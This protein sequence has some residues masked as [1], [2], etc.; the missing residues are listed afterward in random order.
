MVHTQCAWAQ[1]SRDQQHIIT[2]P[3]PLTGLPGQKGEHSCRTTAWKAEK[4]LFSPFPHGEA[5]HLCLYR[6]QPLPKGTS[7]AMG[8]SHA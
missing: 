3:V 6:K 8:K 4:G 7:H 5:K 2:F 1:M